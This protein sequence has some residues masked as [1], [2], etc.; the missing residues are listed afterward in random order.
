MKFYFKISNKNKLKRYRRRSRP[1]LKQERLCWLLYIVNIPRL[2][3]VVLVVI[4][5]FGVFITKHLLKFHWGW[6][7]AVQDMV[8]TLLPWHLVE[9]TW[10]KS[11][12]L[13]KSNLTNFVYKFHNYLHLTGRVSELETLSSSALYAM[14]TVPGTWPTSCESWPWPPTV[15]NSTF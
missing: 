15:H 13:L 5:V 4:R 6:Q 8:M 12:L 10:E 7:D 9:G 14:A 3:S 2:S 11:I 1:K